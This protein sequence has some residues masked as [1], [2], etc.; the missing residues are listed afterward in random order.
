MPPRGGYDYVVLDWT[1]DSRKIMVRANRTPWRE[2]MG[3]YFLVSLDGGLEQPL[4]IPEGGSGRLSPDNG[5]IVYTPIEREFRTWKR[6]KGGRA[7]D[8]WT[9]DLKNN[10]SE[11][12]DRLRRHRPAPAL[13]Q[14]QDLLR[15]R[16]RPGAQ[17]LFL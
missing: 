1:A 7:Q 12:A 17:F 3:K 5:S 2:R 6:T 11:A 16:P 13:V 15:L 4:Q 9:Y 10:V 8:I 14:G